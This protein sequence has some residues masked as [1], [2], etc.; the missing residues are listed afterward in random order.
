VQK[1]ESAKALLSLLFLNLKTKPAALALCNLNHL[2]FEI[3][4]RA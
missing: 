1:L 4:C 2:C 3:P